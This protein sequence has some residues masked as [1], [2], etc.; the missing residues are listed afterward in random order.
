MRPSKMLPVK[1][2]DSHET[3]VARRRQSEYREKV[4]LTDDETCVLGFLE[5][6]GIARQWPIDAGHIASVQGEIS[7]NTSRQ[8]HLY[9]QAV[10]QQKH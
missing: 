10:E 5:K 1:R 4:K 7:A 8:D 9:R 3:A 2:P 6:D